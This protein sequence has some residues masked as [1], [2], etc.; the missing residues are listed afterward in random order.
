MSFKYT[1]ENIN[2]KKNKFIKI[3]NYDQ[4]TIDT[5]NQINIINDDESIINN[6]INIENLNNEDD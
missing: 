4:D 1:E 2:L 3:K 5:A 6:S